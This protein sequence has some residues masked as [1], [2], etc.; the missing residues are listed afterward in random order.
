MNDNTDIKKEILE[1]QDFLLP[2]KMQ[3]NDIEKKHLM[4]KLQNAVLNTAYVSNRLDFL[5]SH[6]LQ[7]KDIME[8]LEEE[9]PIL[10]IQKVQECFIAF[11]KLSENTLKAVAECMADAIVSINLITDHKHAKQLSTRGGK[12]KESIY[13]KYYSAIKAGNASEVQEGLGFTEQIIK[14][15]FTDE[16]T[17]ESLLLETNSSRETHLKNSFS[18]FSKLLNSYDK[19]KLGAYEVEAIKDITAVLRKYE[20]NKLNEE[21]IS[22]KSQLDKLELY[23]QQQ[24]DIMEKEYKEKQSMEKVLIKNGIAKIK[25]NQI[26]NL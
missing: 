23:R 8:F 25:K 14:D 12:H 2:V 10:R 19:N 15:Y 1:K 11:I 13:K 24:L 4:I 6:Y 9:S 5:T 18:L 22:L 7:D 20:E 3:L 16:E 21:N 17:G 26:K